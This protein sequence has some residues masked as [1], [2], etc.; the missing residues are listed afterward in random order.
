MKKLNMTMK[1]A[2]EMWNN[3]LTI[4]GFL[5]ILVLIIS[6]FLRKTE[7]V[8]LFT[9]ILAIVAM[10]SVAFFCMILYV[11]CDVQHNE[12]LMIGLGAFGTIV[13]YVTQIMNNQL[14]NKPAIN[15]LAA[16]F[17]CIGVII[18]LNKNYKDVEN[19]RG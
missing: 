14:M 12:I 3:S 16:T 6:C 13:G 2:R 9:Q 11:S 10:A 7:T 19:T 1:R 15:N 17:L 4:I 5:G 18:L 8:M